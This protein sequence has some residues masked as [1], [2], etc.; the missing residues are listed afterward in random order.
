LLLL[1]PLPSYRSDRERIMYP[2]LF[3][4]SSP[5]ATFRRFSAAVGCAELPV[6]SYLLKNGGIV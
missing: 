2:G 4:L 3:R 6:A 1:L 5:T